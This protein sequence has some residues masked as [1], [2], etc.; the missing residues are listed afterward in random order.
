MGRSSL[1]AE[2]EGGTLFLDH[3]SELPASAQERLARIVRD[4]EVRRAGSDRRAPLAVRVIGSS[5]P[6]IDLEVETGAFRAD[7]LRRLTAVRIDVPPLRT[8]PEDMT[9]ITRLLLRE[10]EEA[11]GLPPRQFTRAALGFLSALPWERNLDELR[12]VLRQVVASGPAGSVRVEDLLAHVRVER[13]LPARPRSLR[14]A[15]R[16]FEREYIVAVVDH[17][18]GRMGDAARALGI[19]R[20]NLYRKARQLGIS[21]LKGGA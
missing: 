12:N 5:A 2:A 7:L 11:R 17:C 21:R 20:T 10:I 19:Q 15:R 9:A 14:E 6:S 1:L 8:R 16:D 18:G 3:V 4:G 13:R